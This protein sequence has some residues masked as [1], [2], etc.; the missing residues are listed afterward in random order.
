M[1]KS[2]FYLHKVEVM[3][4]RMRGLGLLVLV[5]S[6]GVISVAEDTPL[7]DRKCFETGSINGDTEI[8]IV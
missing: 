3:K 2:V 8:E 6:C 5:L 7:T 1:K 4:K